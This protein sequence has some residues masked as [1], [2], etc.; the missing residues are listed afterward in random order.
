M[1]VYANTFDLNPVSGR[2]AII[3]LVAGWISHSR[4][5][6]VDA[7]RLSL[8][9]FD[10]RMPNKATLS[11]R[12]TVNQDG[13]PQFPYFFCAR[14]A[15]GQDD[16]PG[17]RWITEIGLRQKA[18][19][20]IITCSVVLET[21][22]VSAKVTAPIQ[23]TR[24]R[25]VQNLIENCRPVGDTVGLGVL[26]LTNENA[27]AFVHNVE[28]SSRR[29]PII[30]ISANREGKYP[31]DPERMRS[32]AVGLA[33]TVKVSPG[34]DTFKLQE[35][36]GRRYIAFGGTINI[37]FP[38]RKSEFS[39]FC[40]S[41]LIHPDQMEELALSGTTVEAEVLS[42]ITHLTN[43]PNSWR[44]ISIDTVSQEILRMRLE[45][46]V[47]EIGSSD[48]QK[49]YEGLL[50]EAA[51]NINSA[52][53]KM[54]ALQEELTTTRDERDF[55]EA[56][57]ESLKHALNGVQSRPVDMSEQAVEAF[58][59]LRVALT[60]I[61][62]GVPTLE[63]SLHTISSLYSD[64]LFILD[65]ALSSARISDRGAFRHGAKAFDLLRTL[66]GTYWEA[67]ASGKPDQVAREVF[68]SS[69]ASKEANI[70]N[71]GKAART[72]KYLNEDIFMEKHLKIGTKDSLAETLR[73]H[74]EWFPSE[75][76]IVIG[77]C[78]KHI[79]F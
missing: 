36:V 47:S 60:S 39:K 29:D 67:L 8:G 75:Q 22:E 24:P 5:V 30:L 9:I 28:Y 76:K 78:G 2:Q 51:D 35:V 64:R 19:G 46:A 57:A 27:R 1:L 18:D 42:T 32:L 48:E 16:V 79:D 45:K 52:N 63:Q 33:Q 13:E 56:E 72:F 53:E 11:S 62:D 40:K 61:F 7:E 70:S 17:R 43:L 71:A 73:V 77:H 12:A 34:I 15:H 59:N 55:A 6:A 20:G 65:T 44:H 49:V 31:V 38:P 66:A 26:P 23:V 41:V 3:N 68:G 69:Y 37:I 50:Q 54:T 25:I 21:S 10:Y 74:F 58:S 4:G 14:L